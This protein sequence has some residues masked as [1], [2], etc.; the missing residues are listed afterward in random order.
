MR[1]AR[2]INLVFAVYAALAPMA[3][4]LEL[5]NKLALNAGLWLGVQKYLYRGWGPVL[6]AP[7]EIGALLSSVLLVWLHARS[8]VRVWPAAVAS[9]CYAGMLAAFFVL[10]QPVNTAVAS[11]TTASLPPDWVMY[12][13]HWE[14]GHAIAAAL[15]IV[16]LT[17]LVWAQ[18]RERRVPRAG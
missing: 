14:A 4:V 17:V 2:R 10:N 1:W 7:S 5:S 11:W 8:R 9:M 12:R 13:A 3:R 6:G 16:A 15:S 18:A